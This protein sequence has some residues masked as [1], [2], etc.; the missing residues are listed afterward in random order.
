MAREVDGM[1]EHAIESL[2][3]RNTDLAEAI[4]RSDDI[5]DGMN[6]HIEQECLDLIALQQPV[7]RHLRLVHVAF[8]V[9]TD[10]ERIG[11]HGVDIAKITR[12]LAA[13]WDGNVPEDLIAMGKIVQS[14]LRDLIQALRTPDLKLIEEIASSREAD[15]AF[16]RFQASTLATMQD[17]EVPRV[18]AHYLL[19]VAYH[20]DEM[21]QHIADAAKRLRSYETGEG[22]K[23][24][25][26]A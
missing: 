11:D 15:A 13:S 16:E 12:K 5:V 21:A 3:N 4:L 23:L 1:L 6:V 20:L 9:V 22:R 24:R 2:V 8:N 17:S 7:A 19:F 14:M 18:A 10:L 25:M 26:A